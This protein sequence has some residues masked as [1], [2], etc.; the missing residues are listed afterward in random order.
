MR[1]IRGGFPWP[2]LYVGGASK[3]RGASPMAAEMQ[4]PAVQEMQQEAAPSRW[5]SWRWIH[6][7]RSKSCSTYRYEFCFKLCSMHDYRKTS[8]LLRTG[9]SF[10]L[11]V[12]PGRGPRAPRRAARPRP[13]HASASRPCCAA[14]A[15]APSAARTSR[16]GT[17]RRASLASTSGMY[18]GWASRQPSL[19]SMRQWQ[20]LQYA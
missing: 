1:C 6:S 5:L 13:N 9:A 2:G 11:Q 14:C 15:S 3:A 7:R 18:A 4:Q 17:S 20:N 10:L 16:I 12:K 8:E 19:G